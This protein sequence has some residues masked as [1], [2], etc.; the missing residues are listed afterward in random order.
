[1]THASV[2]PWP[3]VGREAELRDLAAIFD[4]PGAAAG[5]IMGEPGSGKTRLAE[6]FVASRCRNWQVRRFFAA[7]TLRA[8]PLGVF[9]Q[10]AAKLGS[11]PF[12]KVPAVIARLETAPMGRRP[13]VW[14]DD[15]QFLDDTSAYVVLNLLKRGSVAVLMTARTGVDCP[16]S[17]SALW[18]THGVCRVDVGPLSRAD[19]CNAIERRLGGPLESAA[20]QWFWE[21]TRGNCLYLQ[22]LVEGE[23]RAGRLRFEGAVW[24]WDRQPELSPNLR[25]VVEQRIGRVGEPLLSVI[26]FLSVCEPLPVEVMARLVSADAVEQA[27]SAGLVSVDNSESKTVVRLGHPL[28]GDVRRAGAG[29]L[30]LARMRDQLIV[31]LADG[32]PDPRLTLQ[33]ARLALDAQAEPDPH[34]MLAGAKAALQTVDIDLANRLASAAT[35]PE[36]AALDD[37]IDYATTLLVLGRGVEVERILAGPEVRAAAPDDAYITALR[38][39]NDVSSSSDRTLANQLLVDA[40][41]RYEE[42]PP[43]LRAARAVVRTTEGRYREALS[44]TRIALGDSGLPT[45]LYTAALSAATLAAGYVGDIAEMEQASAR[46]FEMARTEPTLAPMRFYIAVVTCSSYRMAGLP[47]RVDALAVRLREET[48]LVPPGV[49][50]VATDV[51]SGYRAFCR[52]NLRAT[53]RHIA[54]ALAQPTAFVRTEIRHLMPWALFALIEAH[55]RSGNHDIARKTLD[56]FR[57]ALPRG[58]AGL[59]AHL[60]ITEAWV[61]A[62][63]EHVDAAI[64]LAL[65]TARGAGS[66]GDHANEVMALQAATQLGD[67]TTGRRLLELAGSVDGPRARIAAQHAKALAWRSPAD[68]DASSAAYLQIGDQVAAADAAA[69]AS[70]HHRATG[71]VKRAQWSA[72]RAMQ[73]AAECGARTTAVKA[74][75]APDLTNRER[76]IIGLVAA[77]RTYSQIGEQLGIS[78]RTVEGHVRQARQ[79]VGAAN[80]QELVSLVARSEG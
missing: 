27:E 35:P 3:F 59:H 75:D 11:D 72:A 10:F 1:M 39:I 78:A 51:L 70:V 69:Q 68:L 28:F 63:E 62:A 48:A 16:E 38:V 58:L 37:R 43:V 49:I 74:C 19:A 40:D 64:E 36:H 31:G 57:A 55:A 45:E 25:D 42:L 2:Q 32:P 44:D 79:K 80:R 54:A 21:M 41:M 22:E 13:L 33:R 4:R 66:R 6:H 34:L 77:G 17:V 8:I 15:V 47:D 23:R 76:E 73:I 12:A 50:D 5:V 26:D 67:A 24:V 61:L 7:P 18:A 52:G 9:G 71:D 46:A 14:I 20:R 30:R 65:E 56:G 29:T 60:A 53:I